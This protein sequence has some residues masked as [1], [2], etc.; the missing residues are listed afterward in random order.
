MR[1]LLVVLVVLAACGQAVDDVPA[2]PDDRVMQSAPFSVSCG[3]VAVSADGPS[4][5]LSPAECGELLGVEWPGS[6][7]AALFEVLPDSEVSFSCLWEARVYRW[8][9]SRAALEPVWCSSDWNGQ[10]LSLSPGW[11]LLVPGP[12]QERSPGPMLPVIRT[13][14]GVRV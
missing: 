14:P 3:T 9:D 1:W 10:S 6:S 11:Y 4:G 2:V 7:P 8:D 12:I 5:S 13:V